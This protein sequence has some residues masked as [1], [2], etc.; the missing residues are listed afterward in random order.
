MTFHFHLPTHLIVTSNAAEDLINL[1]GASL[2]PSVLFLSDHGIVK[3]GI[4][5]PVLH[6]VSEAGIPFALF[7]DIPE[8]PNVEA[9]DRAL[10]AAIEVEATHIVALG[11]GSVIDTAKAVGILASHPGMLWE[12][13]QWGRTA[14][15]NPAIPVIAIP[16]TAGTGS[17]V[18]HVTVIGDR[19]GFKKG[20]VHAQVF[21]KAAILDGGLTRSLPSRLT[22][23]TGMDA[24]VHAVEAY[25]G[26][27]SNPVTDMYALEAMQAIVRW[28]PVAV[29]DG[30]NLA[31][32]QQMILSATYAGIAMDQSGL[33]LAHALCGP[34]A[35]KYH[36]H[37][38]LGVAVLLPATLAFNA[39]AIQPEKW[40]ALSEALCLPEDSSPQD[41]GQW[42]RDF[43][44]N[45]DLPVLLSE[46]GIQAADL[47]KIAA[48]AGRMAMFANNV[49]QATLDDCI[50]LLEGAL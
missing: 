4:G 8:N 49:R 48:D 33:G 40:T 26:K 14:I 13:L 32:R 37:H 35:G 46:L 28:L 39:P 50:E 3:A 11:G 5:E 24:L 2:D 25:L 45:L 15:Q 19:T 9:V 18:T 43:L 7:R 47:P 30:N 34:L 31:A 12:D 44:R 21:P 38:G 29:V 36:L 23:A 20:V 27:R 17:E 16:T 10:A 1:L 42:A 41:L 6:Q 22:A